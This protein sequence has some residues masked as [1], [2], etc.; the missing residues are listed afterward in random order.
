M[1]TSILGTYCSFQTVIEMFSCVNECMVLFQRFI[2]PVVSISVCNKSSVAGYTNN[3]QSC[4]MISR[5]DATM[6]WNS[7]PSNIIIQMGAF[8][9]Y[10]YCHT[11]VRVQREM[12][13]QRKMIWSL[14]MLGIPWLSLVSLLWYSLTP[15]L[16]LRFSLL[17]GAVL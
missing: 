11:F 5:S 8:T 3:L 14:D 15:L 10:Q 7:Q 16:Q 9:T 1:V 12:V 4:C 13:V 2:I 17:S 6:F